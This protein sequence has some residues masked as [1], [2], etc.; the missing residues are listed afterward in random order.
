[1]REYRKKF[2]LRAFKIGNYFDQGFFSE[3][4]IIGGIDEAEVLRH[5]DVI[6]WGREL[7]LERFKLRPASR[8]HL[9][10]PAR[11]MTI[12]RPTVPSLVSVGRPS[13]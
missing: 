4:L 1:M 6:Q 9:C 2:Q 8:K 7:R 13:T 11:S 3:E 10:L 12:G 5:N